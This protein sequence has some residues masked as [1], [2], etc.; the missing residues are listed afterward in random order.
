MSAI[1]SRQG[2][3]LS[4]LQLFALVTTGTATITGGL[5]FT[6]SMLTARLFIPVNCCL[7]GVGIVTLLVLRLS[8]WQHL[9]S[10]TTFGY[11]IPAFLIGAFIPVSQ[12]AT[13]PRTFRT[14]RF[15][16]FPQTSEPFD[17]RQTIP[18]SSTVR[19]QSHSATV[20]MSHG[21]SALQVEPLLTFISTS[22]DRF[23][24]LFS[25]TRPRR[26]RLVNQSADTDS[27]IAEYL[28]DHPS[29]LDVHAELD[30][31]RVELETH[32]SLRRPVFSHLNSYTRIFVSGTES[33][34]ISFASEGPQIA[35]LPSDYPVG[36]AARFAALMP[37][38]NLKVLEASSGEK[39]PFKILS[40]N[41]FDR[42]DPLV[43]TIHHG[44]QP[45][46]RITLLDW[47]A[48][49][50]THLSPTAGWGVPENAVEFSLAEGG[51]A[52]MIDVT[53][54]GTSVGR[55]WDSVG[56][57]S[58]TYRNRMTVEYLSTHSD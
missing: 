16:E 13:D 21:A 7:W 56:H 28:S 43:M 42:D 27:F 4:R 18:L 55:G 2:D 20:T 38:G 17:G 9:K 19:I 25:P 34:S 14:G 26:H 54:A 23:W 36:R 33:P 5:L 50:S 22:P 24:T 44:N 45:V 12:K 11:V 8:S 49:A 31:R 1:L 39:G 58:G 6:G 32:T 30:G 35:I 48:Q 53:L 37:D 29:M 3:L 41:P 40:S 46:Y 15:P 10:R 52:A 47:G 51:R 57:N